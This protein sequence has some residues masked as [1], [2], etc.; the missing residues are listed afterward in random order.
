MQEAQAL[1]G[2][3]YLTLTPSEREHTRIYA[4]TT[5]LTPCMSADIPRL[6][7]SGGTSLACLQPVLD[8]ATSRDRYVVLTDGQI[9]DLSRV[10]GR[11]AVLSLAPTQVRDPRLVQWR[12]SMTHAELERASKQVQALL[13]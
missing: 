3:I 4:Y 2:A 13:R 5:S 12:T 9:P 1:A 11:I 6:Y 8:R 10:E 7:A